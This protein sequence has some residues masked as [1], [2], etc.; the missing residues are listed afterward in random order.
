MLP[1][2]LVMVI[3]ELSQEDAALSILDVEVDS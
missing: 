3:E 1:P 2:G